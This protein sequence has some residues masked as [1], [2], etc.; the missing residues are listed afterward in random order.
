MTIIEALAAGRPVVATASAASRTSSTRARP[1]ILVRAG[2][3]HA[4][5]ERLALIAAD[6]ERPRAHGRDGPAGGARALRGRRAS[7]TT[8]TRSTAGC[9]A[10]DLA[11]DAAVARERDLAVGLPLDPR[12][13]ALAHPVERR[14]PSIDVAD[15]R[16]RR[17]RGGPAARRG[18]TPSRSTIATVSLSSSA[19]DEHRPAGGEDPVE[20]ARD[21]E[22]GEPAREPDVVQVAPRRATRA[23]PRRGW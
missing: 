13:A 2:D 20:A 17:A 14:R 16:R 9:C 18:R 15:R 6:P 22:A 5:A 4:L 21:D 7:S 3:T 12:A 10:T 8:S 11:D 23:A 19:D 1:A